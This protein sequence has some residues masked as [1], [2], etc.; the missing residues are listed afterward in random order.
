VEQ[1][2]YGTVQPLAT[3]NADCGF[4]ERTIIG[5]HVNA[6]KTLTRTTTLTQTI[7]LI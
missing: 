3:V 7:N 5:K 6:D 1:F 4:A 2:V